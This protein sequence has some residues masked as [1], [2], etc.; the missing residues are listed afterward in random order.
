M[1]SQQTPT[2]QLQCSIGSAPAV[3]VNNV[4]SSFERLDDTVRFSSRTT[5]Y[6]GNLDRRLMWTEHNA[7]SEDINCFFR[8][9]WCGL[10]Q[11][12]VVFIG[13]WW[14]ME[15][16]GYNGPPFWDNSEWDSVDIP[17]VS[18]GRS[19]RWVRHGVSL[20]HVRWFLLLEI[21]SR[22]ICKSGIYQQHIHEI[23]SHQI[24]SLHHNHYH[25][26]SI[27]T[28]SIITLFII[29]LSSIIFTITPINKHHS[30]VFVDPATLHWVQWPGGDVAGVFGRWNSWLSLN[31]THGKM[32]AFKRFHMVKYGLIWLNLV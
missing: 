6:G 18:P 32:L 29:T 4:L 14:P 16:W 31:E 20:P 7:K 12:M 25:P 24:P 17:A 3:K 21:K 26:L 2:N 28:L 27:I 1:Q 15:F 13:N 30:S 10:P 8:W 19:L 23:S 5:L 9:T 11:F 22:Y